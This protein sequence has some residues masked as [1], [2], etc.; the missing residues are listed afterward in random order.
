LSPEVTDDDD[1]L[2]RAVDAWEQSHGAAM[3]VLRELLRHQARS[4]PVGSADD[5]H[6]AD[7]VAGAS[8]RRAFS[9][10]ELSEAWGVSR[11]T[12]NKLLRT[13]ELRAFRVGRRLLIPRE[14][15]EGFERRNMSENGS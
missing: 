6:G 5:H 15:V 2:K 3:A 7:G 4:R 13:G 1:A 9:C 14:Q 11:T 8:E 12:I 10:D